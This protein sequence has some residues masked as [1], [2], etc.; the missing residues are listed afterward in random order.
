MTVTSG[1]QTHLTPTEHP[2]PLAVRTRLSASR[3][4]VTMDAIEHYIAEH[5][6]QPGDPLPTESALCED[7]GVSRSSVREALRQL[8]ALEIVTVQQ[9]RGAFVGEMSMRPLVKTILLRSS[10]APDSVEAL[11]QVVAM[12]RVID[13]G[14]T[15]EIC[16]ALEGTHDRELHDLVEMMIA[17]AKARTHFMD[18]DVAFHETLIRRI[19][20][21]LVEQLALAMW[22]IHMTALPSIT[23][24]PTKLLATA[25][26][27]QTM[28][29]AAEAGDRM[30]YRKAVTAHY[31]PLDTLITAS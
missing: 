18:E 11:R 14:L 10:I 29:E 31:D 12:R 19:D 13:L 21:P 24:D 15:P 28:L 9:G 26:A 27:H 3:A 2:A 4:E 16:A 25:L 23:Q 8:Q 22:K 20:N 5:R 7:L 17:K 30:A 6:L 1:S